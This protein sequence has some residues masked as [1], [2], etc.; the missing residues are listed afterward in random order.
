[1]DNFIFFLNRGKGYFFGNI[2]I[3]F[4]ESIVISIPFAAQ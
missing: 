2:A 4:M 3:F 1:M